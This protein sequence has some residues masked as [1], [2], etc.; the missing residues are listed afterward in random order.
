MFN[1]IT[2]FF[3]TALCS[4]AFA[5]ALNTARR[6]YM[7]RRQEHRFCQ[8]VRLGMSIERTRIR[9]R[10]RMIKWQTCETSSAQCS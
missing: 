7:K 8:L 9:S 5:A 6:E 1:S 2:I 4:V 3:V 10:A